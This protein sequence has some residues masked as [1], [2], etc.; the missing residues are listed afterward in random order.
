MLELEKS[1]Y[2][3]IIYRYQ[4]L[5]HIKIRGTSYPYSYAQIANLSDYDLIRYYLDIQRCLIKIKME[6]EE[7]IKKAYINKDNEIDSEPYEYDSMILNECQ[8]DTFLGPVQPNPH[9]KIIEEVRKEIDEQ[10]LR[11]IREAKDSEQNEKR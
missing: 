2:V 6:T 1:K 4:N 8:N 7:Q 10:N 9:A 5:I 11:L 3:K